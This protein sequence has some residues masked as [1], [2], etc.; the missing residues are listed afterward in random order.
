[1]VFNRAFSIW[2]AICNRWGVASPHSLYPQLRKT[3]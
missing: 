1:M 2:H 3:L